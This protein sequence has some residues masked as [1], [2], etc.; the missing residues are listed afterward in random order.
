MHADTHNNIIP[1]NTMQ[2]WYTT[3]STYLVETDAFCTCINEKLSEVWCASKCVW[4][5]ILSTLTV[6]RLRKALFNINNLIRDCNDLCRCLLSAIQYFCRV[7]V[8]GD[9]RSNSRNN[10]PSFLHFWGIT[11]KDVLNLTNF[12]LFAPSVYIILSEWVYV[13]RNPTI[14]TRNWS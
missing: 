10:V 5:L 3:W 6:M 14:T 4:C 11:P 13:C 8:G 9:Q 1:L 12:S 2:A 7:C